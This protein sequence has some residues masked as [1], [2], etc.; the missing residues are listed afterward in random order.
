MRK[1]P[2]VQ[3]S[4]FAL[5]LAFL[6][7]FALAGCQSLT[8]PSTAKGTPTATSAGTPVATATPGGTPTQPY[9]SLLIADRASLSDPTLIENV[10]PTSGRRVQVVSI[11]AASTYKSQAISPDGQLTAY[12]Q[13]DT[14]GKL[15]I[16]ITDIA[17]LG[18]PQLV[19]QSTGPYS[20]VVWQHDSAHV[21]VASGRQLLIYSK[22]GQASPSIAFPPAASL[23]GFT[24]D[25]QYLFFVAAAGAPNLVAGALYRLPLADPAHPVEVTPRQ[26]GAHFVLSKDA[27]MVYYDNTGSGDAGIYRVGT[28]AANGTPQLVVPGTAN[29]A[30]GFSAAGD[31]LF[32]SAPTGTLALKSVTSAGTV[33]TVVAKLVDDPTKVRTPALQSVV[34]PDGTGIAVVS[35]QSTSGF[36]IYYTDLTASTPAPKVTL[37]LTSTSY[38]DLSGWDIDLVAAG[39]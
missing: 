1:D 6:G 31:L 11:P 16:Y 7:V 4:R 5:F 25:D 3:H 36:A 35:P 38:L 24:P 20:N 19:T 37:T 12:E 17:G 15:S 21:A 32:V 14:G 28:T 18:T 8:S 33:A 29:Y 2:C 23:L 26:N 30:L 13:L 22:T 10:N 9:A 34:A 39:S 27:T